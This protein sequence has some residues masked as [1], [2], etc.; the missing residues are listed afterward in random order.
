MF[1]FH[2]LACFAL[3]LVAIFATA[4]PARAGEQ[5]P[6]HASGLRQH[7]T[8]EHVPGGIHAIVAIPN[9]ESNLGDWEGLAD[10]NIHGTTTS[11]P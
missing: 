7:V 8:A 9:G 2:L 6:L 11:E 4:E 3:P 1:R 5:F 10:L